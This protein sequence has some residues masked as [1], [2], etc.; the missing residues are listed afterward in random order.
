MSLEIWQEDNA[1]QKAKVEILKNNTT[2]YSIRSRRA[3]DKN[4]VQAKSNEDISKNGSKTLYQLIKITNE[5]LK[6]LNGIKIKRNYKTRV[7]LY[8][9]F[10]KVGEIENIRQRFQAD[11][12]IEATWEDNLIVGDSFDPEKYWHP[13][14][15]IENTVGNIKQ[16]IKYK[17]IRKYG[18]TFVCEMRNVKGIFYETLELNDFPLDIQDI[19]ITITSSKSSN[20]IEF[21]LSNDNE[22]SINTE[23]FSKKFLN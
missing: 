15:F 8:A 3:H 23:D 14:L 4:S 11:A 12:Y 10:I 17:I 2:T 7:E 19:S 21:E 20:E 22:S 13:D 9:C 18:K 1:Q 16:E 5:K 6:N